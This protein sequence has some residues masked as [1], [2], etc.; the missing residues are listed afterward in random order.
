MW[1]VPP[2]PPRSPYWVTGQDVAQETDKWA[3]WATLASAA[4]S[5]HF[6]VSCATSCL[7]THYTDFACAMVRQSDPAVNQV[8]FGGLWASPGKL[9]ILCSI[10]L[11]SSRGNKNT[12]KMSQRERSGV[13]WAGDLLEE[14]RLAPRVAVGGAADYYIR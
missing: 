3:E 13:G 1:T 5:P 4:V 10:V 11:F 9:Y 8:L 14:G 2:L 12:G 6:S 7:V